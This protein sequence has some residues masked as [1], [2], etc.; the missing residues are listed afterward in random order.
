MYEIVCKE[1]ELKPGEMKEATLGRIPIVICRTPDGELYAF[2]NRCIHQGAPMSKGKLC[3]APAPTDI[4]GEY[5]FIQ[6]GEILRCP[7]HGREFDVKN[8]GRMLASPECKLPHYKVTIVGDDV[9]VHKG[10]KTN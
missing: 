2:F 3:G 4:V 1:Y 6:E 9:V 7:W 10:G 8:E 5:R